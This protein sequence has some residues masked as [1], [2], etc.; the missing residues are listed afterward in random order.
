M[1]ALRI[2]N[3]SLFEKS[4]SG[5]CKT[6]AWV[7]VPT[8]HDGLGYLE[9]M[10]HPDGI[11]MIGGW[12]LILQ[13]ASKCPTRGLLVADSG[14]ILGAREIALKTRSN[15]ADIK[16]CIATLLE[17]GWLEE[18]DSSGQHPDTIRTAS[19]HHPDYKTRQDRTE[20]DK[21]EQDNTGAIGNEADS[22]GPLFTLKSGSA[23]RLS[24]GEMTTLT[25]TFPDVRITA[26]IQAAASWTTENPKRAPKSGV[27]RFVLNWISRNHPK[28][29]A[30]EC[31]PSERPSADAIAAARELE[32]QIKAGLV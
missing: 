7:A 4:D 19:G 10:S 29:Q 20:Q 3:W 17:N 5:K 21:T 23:A 26:E 12:L 8:N 16:A 27:F 11:R 18:V 1:K 32:A 15:E 31:P 30:Y 14:R 22:I 24:V 2:S 9:L 25:D 6:M 13:V 28:P